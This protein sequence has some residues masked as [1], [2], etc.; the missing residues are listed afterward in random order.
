M[1]ITLAEED[2]VLRPEDVKAV[3]DA[4]KDCLRILRLKSTNDPAVLCLASKIMELAK[5]GEHNQARLRE[6]TLKWVGRA[7]T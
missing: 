7:S 3:A 6:A 2:A 5:E 4:F 1:F